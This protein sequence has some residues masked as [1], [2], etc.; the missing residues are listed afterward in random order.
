MVNR[1]YELTVGGESQSS[2]GGRFA[3]RRVVAPPSTSIFDQ[4]EDNL[5]PYKNKKPADSAK[6]GSSS[7]DSQDGAKLSRR[8]SMGKQAFGF[9]GRTDDLSS[10]DH[11]LKSINSL[12]RRF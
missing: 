10:E 9:K 6:K 11:D 2:R 4:I 1:H 8:M 3:A 5:H 12:T 7:V